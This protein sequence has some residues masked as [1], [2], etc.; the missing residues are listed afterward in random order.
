MDQGHE[1]FVDI[2][3]LEYWF[4]IFEQN[5]NFSL[6]LKEYENCLKVTAE[7]ITYITW[8]VIWAEWDL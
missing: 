2:K 1:V 4:Q 6:D 7:L 8:R 5:K 3:P